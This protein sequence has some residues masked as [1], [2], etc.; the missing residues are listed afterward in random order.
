MIFANDINVYMHQK[1]IWLSDTARTMLE[2]L[3]VFPLEDRV[4]RRYVIADLNKEKHK[5]HHS[6]AIMLLHMVDL[7][8]WPIRMPTSCTYAV[9]VDCAMPTDVDNTR[10]VKSQA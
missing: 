1:A 10:A 7:I 9:V 3:M 2:S 4:P 6:H 5:W 8:W